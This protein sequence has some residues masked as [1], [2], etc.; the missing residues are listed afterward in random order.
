MMGNRSGSQDTIKHI[1]YETRQ[2]IRKGRDG[3]IAIH[4][5]MTT[6]EG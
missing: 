3:N 1:N 6:K 5:E 2:D 4:R